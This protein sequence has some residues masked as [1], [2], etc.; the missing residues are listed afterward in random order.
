MKPYLPICLIFSL[1]A[2]CQPQIA[3]KSDLGIM[4]SVSFEIAPGATP[5]DFVLIN[6]TPGAFLTRWDLGS[7]G[8]FTG[9]SVA[10]NFSYKGTYE[11]E[12][13][14]FV[15]AGSGTATQSLT[16]TQ[17]DPNACENALKLLTG[18][19]SKV[20]KLAPEPNALHVGP[21]LSDTWWGN[22]TADLTARDC[23][24]DDEYIFSIDGVYTYDNKGDFYADSDANGNVFPP[25]LGLSVGCHPNTAWPTAYA[26]WGSNV[27]SFALTSTSLT[28]VGQGAWIG[29][30][31]IGTA[32]EVAEPQ[33]A[34]SLSIAE[35]TESRMVLFADYGWGVWRITLVAQ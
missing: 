24:F 31:K 22:S 30:Y 10:V 5:N 8:T 19:G 34:V 18:C 1:L 14:T 7:V 12:M 28:L 21:N 23:H 11:V 13:T 4:P 26:S 3:D 32:G 33:N 2:A 17:D 29:L 20:W 6:T 16:V 15:R 27:H 25:G 35:L 9:D